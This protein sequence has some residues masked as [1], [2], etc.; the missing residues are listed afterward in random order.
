M[1]FTYDNDSSPEN[2]TTHYRI[3]EGDVETYEPDST[4]TISVEGAD[5][6]IEFWSSDNAGNEELP[7]NI[8]AD[9]N[10]D[11]I[12]PFVTIN[13][14]PDLVFPGEIP[15][16]GTG[17]EYTSGS[18]I[19]KVIIRIND[20]I[21]YNVTYSGEQF[22]W[23][24]WQFSADFGEL[25]DIYIEAY[26]V[27]GNKGVNRKTVTCS[28]RGIYEPGHI[29]IFDNPKIGPL[30][31]LVNLDLTIVVDYDNLFI[32]LPEFHE[33]ATSIKFVAKKIILEQEFSTWDTNLSDGASCELILSPLGFYKITASAYDEEDNIL[34]EYNILNQMFVL[35]IS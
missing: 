13:K 15:L 24:D 18:G 35:L 22:V 25:Y 27:A 20:E 16:N 33:N 34:E 32:V 10:I 7:H 1:L 30:H 4:I 5:N 11:T 23:Y 28:E 21:V 12:S 26:D 2:V 19:Y 6:S 29:Y 17:T 31:L 9:I 8:N 3:N 14:P